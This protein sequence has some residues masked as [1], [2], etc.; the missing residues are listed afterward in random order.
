M[1]WPRRPVA[2]DP[3]VAE[4]LVLLRELSTVFAGAP[5]PLAALDELV[6]QGRDM[7]SQFKTNEGHTLRDAV[8][9]LTRAAL[10]QVVLAEKQAVSEARLE[11][12]V[13]QLT[14]NVAQLSTMLTL[15]VSTALRI[16]ESQVSVAADLAGSHQR[17]DDASETHGAAGDAFGRSAPTPQPHNRR[18]DDVPAPGPQDVSHTDL[19]GDDDHERA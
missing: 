1:R 4:L 17:A 18:Q 3:A 9:K 10:A 6:E 14:T 2:V 5:H 11:E 15:G 19:I 12:L 16:E 13:E 8:D 7:V